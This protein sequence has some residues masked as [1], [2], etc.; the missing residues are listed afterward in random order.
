MLRADGVALETKAMI[1]NLL[2]S[3]KVSCDVEYVINELHK[4]GL[5]TKEEFNQ[6]TNMLQQ[7]KE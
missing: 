4:R 6:V 2:G 1:G 5:C 7:K 3:K